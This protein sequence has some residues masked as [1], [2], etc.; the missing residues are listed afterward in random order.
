MKQFEILSDK[1]LES[2]TGSGGGVEVCV[3]V[4][5][6]ANVVS[7]WRIWGYTGSVIVN[8]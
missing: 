5:G 1:Y 7:I 3:N 8:G 2:I 6:R 4:N